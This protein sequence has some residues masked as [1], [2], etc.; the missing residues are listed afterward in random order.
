MVMGRPKR[1]SMLHFAEQLRL[2]AFYTTSDHQI[3]S[4]LCKTVTNQ[5][6][7]LNKI[8]RI[9]SRKFNSTFHSVITEAFEEKRQ[10]ISSL[11]AL[12][13]CCFSGKLHRAAE[14]WLRHAITLFIC[15]THHLIIFRVFFS[16]L[17]WTCYG[18]AEQMPGFITFCRT[19]LSLIARTRR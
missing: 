15:I 9:H 12:L 16:S 4:F 5:L 19:Y 1:L 2:V 3:M 11:D 7:S 6:R 8:K 10:K 13:H 14:W 18:F 17:N